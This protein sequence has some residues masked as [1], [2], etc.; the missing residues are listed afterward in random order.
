M[1][2]DMDISIVVPLLNEVDSLNELT[3]RVV[4]QLKKLNKTFEIIFIDDGSDDGSF[5]KLLELKKNLDNI[6]IQEKFWKK[7]SP[8]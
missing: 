1:E 2:K 8:C 5:E 3:D 4:G 6:R 7:C